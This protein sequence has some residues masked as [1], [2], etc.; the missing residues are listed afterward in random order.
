MEFA[1]R[2]K[3]L[4][5]QRGLTQ[6]D[7]A[8]LLNMT[9]QNYGR[10]ET[11]NA[12]PKLVTLM[13]IAKI[14][15]ISVDYLLGN[16]EPPQTVIEMGKNESIFWTKQLTPE[17]KL[18]YNDGSYYLIAL[19]DIQGTLYKIKTGESFKLPTNALNTVNAEIQQALT[20][21]IKTERKK[22]TLQV[23]K[24]LVFENKLFELESKNTFTP[25]NIKHITENDR[26]ANES[27]G[28]PQ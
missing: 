24:R 15:N 25:E 21:T 23:F 20:E 28:K 9:N 12:N 4:R 22:I 14:L 27:P 13:Q 17:F 11:Q 5:L 19:Q 18:N 7:M 10:F 8:E 6:Q 16:D 1:K 26:Q 3:M 2:L